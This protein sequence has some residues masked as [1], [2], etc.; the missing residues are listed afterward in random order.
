M[1]ARAK[2]IKRLLYVSNEFYG[3][4]YVYNF[5]SGAEVGILSGFTGP[6]GQCVDKTGDVWIT[7]S[8]Y[9]YGWVVEYAHGDMRPVK[10]L[11]T[12][13]SPNG[14]AIDPKTG[15]LAVSSAMGPSSA[16]ASGIT[17]FKNASATYTEYTSND[18]GY[19]GSPGYDD[20]GNLYVQGLSGSY[21]GLCELPSGGAALVP[22]TTNVLGLADA[23]VMW[24]GKYLT[25]EA[26]S[27]ENPKV[28]AIYRVVPSGPAGVLIA[29]GR[30][31]LYDTA[32]G[33][34]EIVQPFIVGKQNTPAN[35]RQGS[36]IVGSD[37]LCGYRLDYWR[38]PR[39]GKL[40][41][42]LSDAPRNPDGQSVSI[43]ESP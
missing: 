4:V 23:G 10:R 37:T 34:T 17:I 29:V 15:D 19:M 14:C 27:P 7:D 28:T 12:F 32:C 30:T 43:K 33:G 36:V 9:Y 39:G 20:N 18:C 41:R 35:D 26:Q 31:L 13:G 25:V 21:Q 16:T 3:D 11:P 5:D 6:R 24:D 38:Y 1:D 8:G 40:L 42:A 2:A 22:R